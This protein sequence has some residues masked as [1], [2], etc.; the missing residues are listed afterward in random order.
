MLFL[1]HELIAQ[2]ELAVE[3]R[4]GEVLAP[5]A[6]VAQHLRGF[7]GEPFGFERAVAVQHRLQLFRL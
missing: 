5:R 7:D 2:H 4:F 1:Q 3:Q 6:G